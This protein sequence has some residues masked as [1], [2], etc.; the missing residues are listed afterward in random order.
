MSKGRMVEVTCLSCTKQFL[1]RASD[2]KRKGKTGTK[3][4]SRTCAILGSRTA[5]RVILNCSYCNKEFER[6]KKKLKSKT[7]TYFCS[8]QC[9]DLA[10]GDPNHSYKT[11]P[12]EGPLGINTYR[13]QALKVYEPACS[14]CGY[15]QYIELLD[16]DHIDSNRDNNTLTNLQ[17][18]CV[19][20]H[21]IKTRLPHLF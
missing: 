21:S 9:Q 1:A 11:G 3:Y 19:A 5:D 20:C 13:K 18:L 6:R 12:S 4:C 10:S 7:N 16:I 15:S 8:F 17:V 14:R 2:Q